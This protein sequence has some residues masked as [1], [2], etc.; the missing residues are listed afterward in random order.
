MTRIFFLLIPVLLSSIVDSF[1]LLPRSS[2]FSSALHVSSTISNDSTGGDEGSLARSRKK[3]ASERTLY[4]VLGARQKD[5]HQVLKV[6]YTAL[7]RKIHPDLNKGKKAAGKASGYPDLSEIN[8]AWQILSDKDERRRYDRELAAKQ[9]TNGLESFVSFGIDAAIPFLQK[10]ADTTRRTVDASTKAID[11][12]ARGAKKYLE[13][14]ELEEEARQLQLKGNAEESRAKKLKTIS[15][16][17]PR[18][19]KEN[20]LE[21]K[22]AS[23]NV[24][25]ARRLS[26]KFDVAGPLSVDRDIDTLQAAEAVLFESSREL[27]DNEKSLRICEL[28][29]KVTQ[30]ASQLALKKFMEAEKALESATVEE[31]NAQDNYELAL[32]EQKELLGQVKPL[33]SKLDQ[34]REKVRTTLV[35]QQD[36]YIQQQLKNMKEEAKALELSATRLRA[37]AEGLQIEARR[38]QRE[39]N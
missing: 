28:Q 22:S 1:I 5:S 12:G 15:H 26:E 36:R 38:R 33:Q 23:L 13:I 34:A 3:A 16:T 17:L 14:Y 37:E 24:A 7:V 29:A 11:K 20:L 2:S 19:L 35:K 6:R 4:D 32:R 21:G 10:T 27:R 18:K 8:A 9:F 39:Q 31:Q 25:E 30:K